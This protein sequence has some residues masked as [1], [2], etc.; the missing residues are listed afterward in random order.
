MKAPGRQSP[1]WGKPHWCAS[2]ASLKLEA[3]ET[4]TPNGR[5]SMR[6]DQAG[7]PGRT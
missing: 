1:I 2:G 7:V 5:L 6:G 4:D 3:P